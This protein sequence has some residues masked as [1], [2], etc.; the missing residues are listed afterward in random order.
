MFLQLA[1]QYLNGNL[2]GRYITNNHIE[3]LLE[4]LKKSFKVKVEGKS[5]K[6]KNIYSVRIGSGKTKILLWSQMHGNESTT[7]KGLFDF[8]NFLQSEDENAVFIK[9]NYILLCI[10]ILNPDGADLYT[11]ENANNIDLNRDAFN[12]TQTESKLLRS[13]YLD[14]KPDFCYNLHDQR[15]IFGT[16]NTGLP[17]TMSFLSPSYNNECEFNDVRLKA[18]KR[19][20]KINNSL[21]VYIPNQIGRF[22]DAF[23]V[24]CIGDYFTTQG[25][26]TILFEAGHYKNDYQRDEVRKYV[27]I[28]LVSSLLCGETE[29][30]ISGELEDYLRIPQ[31]SK[32]FFDFV[33]RNVKINEN[34]EEKTINFA[35]Q[36]KEELVGGNI[37]FVAEIIQ[38]EN[39]ND[40]IGHLEY[41][42]KGMIFESEY[43]NLPIIHKKA[44]FKLNNMLKYS[45]G[46]LN[47]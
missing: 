36:F 12:V 15:T 23:N 14:F 27:F 8:M 4:L 3:P 22:D 39:L 33:Y 40:T 30:H 19:I 5:E 17:A 44:D 11:R 21:N 34:D 1:T 2:S 32:C 10:P 7:T 24:N 18:V 37:N 45:N 26:P 41:D 29:N 38:I 13:L 9:N 31:N 35:A 42:C 16:K 47:L 28:S 6:D 46:L 20:N 25:T 43:G